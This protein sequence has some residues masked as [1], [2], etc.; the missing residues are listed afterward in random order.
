MAKLY[1][2][3]PKVFQCQFL[4]QAVFPGINHLKCSEFSLIKNSADRNQQ[5]LTAVVYLSIVNI[6]Y[7]DIRIYNDCFFF[8][9]GDCSMVYS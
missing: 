9:H 5:S 1:A 2:D 7:Y 4:L 8:I 3:N 6:V